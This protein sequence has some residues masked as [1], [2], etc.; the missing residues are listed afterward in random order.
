M[1]DPA[2]IVK[3]SFVAGLQPEPDLTVSQ[4]ADEFRV[5]PQKAAA[6]PGRWR[7]DRT[8]YLREVMDCLSPHSPVQR[9]IFMKAAQ[10]GGTEC[11]NNW[12]GYVI[13][14]APGPMMMVQPT[15]DTAKKYSKQRI[16][17][18]IEE[19]P[20][21]N[22]RIS[23]AR[24]RD[25]GN[26]QLVK[27]FT[28]GVLVMT[29]ANSAVGLRSMPVRY[30]FL[31]EVDAYPFDV[32]G[33]GDPAGLAERRTTTFAR[34]KIFL[35]STPTIKDASKIESE[36][37]KSDKRRYFVPC[38]HCGNMDWMRWKNIQWEKD[39]P[40]T[41]K[42]LCET[43]GALISEYHK[44]E[45]L[46]KGEWRS[47]APGDD[48]TVGFH[49]SSLY[50]PLGWFSWGDI[51]RDFLESKNDPPK[52]KKWTNT[53]LGETWEEAYSAK[54]GAEGIAQ[55]AEEYDLYTVPQGGIVLTAG[56]DVQDNRLAV[57][58]RAWGKDEESWLVNWTEIHGDPAKREVWQQLDSM[59]INTE[60]THASGAKMKVTAA[61]VD[62]GGHHTHEVYIYCRE[63][64]KHHIIAVKGQSRSGK[65]PLGKPSKQDINFKNQTIKKGAEL[66]PI[67]T[68]TIKAVIYSR[69]KMEE[70]AGPGIYHWP[71]G[72]ELEYYKQLT[73]E[74]QVTKY[75]N[76][77]PTR[78]WIKKDNARNEA[79]DCEV[80]AYAALQFVYTRVNR[81]SVW[82]QFEKK[83]GLSAKIAPTEKEKEEKPIL[84][85]IKQHKKPISRKRGFAN[86]W[87]VS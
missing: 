75:K 14:H 48:K 71:L 50:S 64:R 28:G 45:M 47:T 24:K 55:R 2:L 19:T 20:A 66:Y 58:V 74:K 65:P 67:G 38:P 87:K 81:N 56:V 12:L 57:V 78:V 18:M 32:D 51:V 35:V 46:L 60:F 33:E 29:G 17:P 40:E 53:I 34:R 7:T 22:E 25:S 80:Y 43:C 72:L 13:H 6:E 5:L 44:T 8:P 73:A 42:L 1:H 69:L 37:E 27:D 61:A 3:Q 30:L 49:V 70:Q 79:L 41:A 62:T 10:V 16:A 23:P 85:P 82:D 52:L 76:G 63:R 68:D 15:V 86:N 54:V 36:Y 26:T 11:G 77:Y 9:V 84:N 21:L 83:W 59:L 31:D 39:I 4:W